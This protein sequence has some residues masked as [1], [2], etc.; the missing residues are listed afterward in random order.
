M[1]AA[2]AEACAPSPSSS[3]AYWVAQATQGMAHNLQWVHDTTG[4]PWWA[5]IPLTTLALKLAL[6]PVSMWQAKTV[7][8][9]PGRAASDPT[10]AAERLKRG[11]LVLAN[12]RLLRSKLGAPHPVWV[13]VNPL[14]QLPVFV[15][16]G[17]ALR[18]MASQHWPG[19]AAEGALWFPDLTQ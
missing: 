3:L 19:L 5:A 4:L 2:A 12:F 11:R 15:V 1:A 13:L 18:G 17:L 10:F 8:P 7:Q 6:L 14:V 9:G 16:T